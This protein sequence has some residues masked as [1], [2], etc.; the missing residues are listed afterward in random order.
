MTEIHIGPSIL[1]AI[2]WGCALNVIMAPALAEKE[3]L[4]VPDVIYSSGFS[5]AGK[6]GMFVSIVLGFFSA[7][8]WGLLIAPAGG[9]LFGG[10]SM[11]VLRE[12]MI[13]ISVPVGV[14][15]S[16]LCAAWLIFFT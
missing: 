6:L 14:V 5:A 11:A 4:R 1:S 2:A 12:A 13:A 3:N 9:M 15:V 8:W 16:L 10:I 7:G